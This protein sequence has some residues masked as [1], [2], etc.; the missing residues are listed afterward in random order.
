MN[1]IKIEL[2]YQEILDGKRKRFPPNTW[3]EDINFDLSRRVTKYLIEHVLQW[4]LD[5][6]RQGWNQKLIQKMKL[7]T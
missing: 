2:I 6:I 5:N 3:N 7:T 4:D 1:S